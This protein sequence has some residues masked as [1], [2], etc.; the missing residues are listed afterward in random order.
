MPLN[1]PSIRALTILIDPAMVPKE[2]WDS[3]TDNCQAIF[4]F[5]LKAAASR[6]HEWESKEDAY[7]W[8]KS[9]RPWKGWDARV[10]KAFVISESGGGGGGV[11]VVVRPLR[12]GAE[13]V[14][15][16]GVRA[17]RVELVSTAE[18]E[19]QHYR[20]SEVLWEAP[21][22]MAEVSH[23]KPVH[24][25]W[26]GTPDMVPLSVRNKISETLTAG[27]GTVSVVEN[28]GHLVPAEK[29]EGLALAIRKIL[30]GLPQ[31]IPPQRTK[32]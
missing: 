18:H 5:S 14:D 27:A 31:G 3:N 12:N 11:W 29:P 23:T 26:G 17:D 30:Q 20:P 32:L 7:A 16:G 19:S 28:A 25:I 10:L 4:T 15:G 6:R 21:R 8:M 24:L 2:L 22:I 13:A 9:R 1:A